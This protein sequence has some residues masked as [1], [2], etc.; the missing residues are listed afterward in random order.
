MGE[1]MSRLSLGILSWRAHATLRKTLDSYTKADLGAAVDEKVIFFNEISDEDRAIA[2]EYGYKATGD[3]K[4]LGLLE[5]TAALARELQGEYLLMLQN[6]CP[7]CVTGKEAGSYLKS[8]VKLL[9]EGKADIVRCRSR[10][11]V[12]EGFSDIL[13]YNRYWG[14][15]I[16]PLLRRI[17]RPAKARR[18]IGRSPYVLKEPQLR[19]PSFVKKVDG[20]LI[21][22]S[23]I[24]NFT[25]QPFLIRKDFFLELLSYASTHPSHRTLHGFQVVEICLNCRWWR[26]QHFKIA[27]G[28]GCFTHN[29]FDDSF[30]KEHHAYNA[31]I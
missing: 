25:D 4:N 10:R 7:V 1:I 27:V 28:E 22:D 29:R 6:D 23:S 26:K 20:F 24:I 15:G 31:N 5:G 11:N 3:V 19:F 8:A 16:L 17:L 14:R 30:R 21:L 12:G 13:G 9:S 18:M 2:A